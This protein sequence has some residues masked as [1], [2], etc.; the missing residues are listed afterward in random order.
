[1]VAKNYFISGITEMLILYFLRQKDCYGYEI[2]KAI[3]DL[4]EGDLSISQNT[5]YTA[6]Y[7]LENEG[8]ISEYTKRVGRKRTRVYYRL[9]PKGLRHLEGLLSVYHSTVTGI[10]KI[11]AKNITESEPDE[12]TKE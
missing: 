5:I 3:T 1:M 11:L 12:P 4:S 10:E 8:M 2:T 7:K 9:K 6:I